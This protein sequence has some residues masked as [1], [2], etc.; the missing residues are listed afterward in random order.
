MRILVF[1]DSHGHYRGM[2]EA[3]KAH[4]EAEAV[5]FLGDGARNFE[6]CKELL[7]DKR[8]YAVTGNN[9]FYCDYPKN[10]VITEGGVNIYITHGH[11]EYVKSGL[12]TLVSAAKEHGCAVV[13]Y[14][15]THRQ[16]TDYY[17]GI[18]LFCPGALLNDEYGA[19]DITDGGIMCLPMKYRYKK[20][21]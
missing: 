15:H 1:S 20:A 8:V 21:D 2:L 5:V 14:G 3:V 11:Y 16:Q 17:N 10:Q 19:V 6:S 4:P 18:Y 12:G 7:K 13:L 9:D